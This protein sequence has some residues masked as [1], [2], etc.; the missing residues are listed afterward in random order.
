MTQERV[1]VYPPPRSVVELSLSTV[2][3]ERIIVYPPPKVE[4]VESSWTV[5]DHVYNY[6]S[7][8][9]VSTEDVLTQNN[10]RT[11]NT[12]QLYCL[13]VNKFACWLVIHIKHSLHFT[14]KH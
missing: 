4:F 13:C 14:I 10:S 2:T 12:L 7:P 11:Y 3:Q 1:I 6:A 8:P 9:P 5:R